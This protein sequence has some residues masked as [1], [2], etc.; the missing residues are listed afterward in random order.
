M[1][2]GRWQKR[3]EG[4]NWGAFGPDDPR[5]LNL[6]APDQVLS[7]RAEIITGEAFCLSLLL[8]L[9]GGRV[10]SITQSAM[11]AVA[12]DHFAVDAYPAKLLGQLP[13]AKVPRYEHYL[14]KLGVILGELWNLGLLARATAVLGRCRFVLAAPPLNLPVRVGSRLTPVGIL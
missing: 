14:F 9:P 6:L 12:S 1:S 3:P 10:L 5:G 7:A 8:T 4:S 11:A 13:A 2:N